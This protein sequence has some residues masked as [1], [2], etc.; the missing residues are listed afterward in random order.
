MG[1]YDEWKAREREPVDAKAVRLNVEMAP[2]R[3]AIGVGPA[4]FE[5]EVTRTVTVVV[6]CYRPDDSGS[7]NHPPSAGEFTCEAFLG[8]QAIALT[9]EE[10]DEARGMYLDLVAAWACDD[11]EL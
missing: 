8:A 1:T 6:T 4:E 11:P 5:M 10:A 3:D 2:A 9:R 7:R